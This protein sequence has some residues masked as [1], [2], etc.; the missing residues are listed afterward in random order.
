MRFLSTF[1]KLPYTWLNLFLILLSGATEGFGLTLFVPLLHIMAGNNL[2]ELPRPFADMIDG[3]THMGFVLNITPLLILIIV[4]SMFALGLGYLQRKLL[5]NAKNRYAYELRNDLFRSFLESSWEYSSH[6]A[7]GEIV[8][9]LNMECSR[10]G[11][12]LGFEVSAVATLLLIAVYLVFSATVSWQLTFIASL[13]GVFMF[14]VVSPLSRRAKILGKR[15]TNVNRDFS[16]IIIE[17]LRALKL[18]KSTASEALAGREISQEN[19]NVRDV[20]VDS[21]MNAAKVNFIT[22]ALP[23]I[24]LTGILGFSHENLELQVPVILVF[25]LF[26]MRVAP[27]IGQFQQQ[28][29][30]YYQHSPSLGVVSE[31]IDASRAAAEDLNK[32]GMVFEAINSS[33]DLK[34]ISF[35]YPRGDGQ[36][37]D[38]VSMSIGRNQIVAIVGGSGAGKSTLIDILTGL[39][40]PNSGVITIDDRDLN[41]Y[42]LNSWRQRI[43]IVIQDTISF[44]ASL[45]DNL[46]VFKPNASDADIAD[47]ISAAHL[48][49]VIADLP[50]GLDTVLGESGIR[51]SGGQKQ[52]IALARALVGKP[53]LLLLDE[54]TSALDTESEHYVQDA[55]KAAADTMTI[56][57]IAH[58]LS[59]VRR[60]DNIYVM[61]KGRV[62]ESGDYASLV[63]RDGRFAELQMLESSDE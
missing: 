13:F 61:E 18:L 9:K 47:A 37:L 35:E 1:G 48:D 53:E 15:V 59:T 42:N 58:R 63:E 17:H 6:R 62:G 49:E 56:V 24:L 14:A 52:R 16:I 12:A 19:E 40:K 32:N 22:Q 33:I 55:I 27:R 41:E 21:E 36:A 51:F 10:S 34:N 38:D 43:G 25:L 20:S 50:D 11:S 3:L 5:I 54:A 29:Q 46:V 26:M 23:V 39:R 8:A 4:F 44:N 2:T 31:M 60:V 28:I 30:T 57:I 7:H 45:R